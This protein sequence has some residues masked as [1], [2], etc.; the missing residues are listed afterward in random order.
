MG[1]SMD[2]LITGGSGFIGSMLCNYLLEENHNVSVLTRSRGAAH[3][4]IPKEVSLYESME[5]FSDTDFFDVIINLAGESLSH[6]RWTAEKKKEI[7]DSR[8]NTTKAVC[9]YITKVQKKPKLLINGS[10]IG[11]YGSQGDESLD[12]ESEPA[13]GFAHDLCHSW[14]LHAKD[15][16]REGV[17]VCY[18][19]LGVVLHPSGGALKQM[20][21]PF[22]LGL[23]GPIGDGGQYFSWIHMADLIYLIQFII[24]NKSVAGPVNATAP[25]PVPNKEFSK[26]LAAV[27]GRPALLKMPAFPLRLIFGEMADE[28]L[29]N[30]QRVIPKKLLDA[31]FK[32]Q[33][34]DIGSALRDLLTDASSADDAGLSEDEDKDD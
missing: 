7:L 29:L 15:A 20:L 9:E 24:D 6:G 34:A 11:Y 27:L 17:R 2:F 5:S 32:F 10:A 4:K 13:T 8:V 23:G 33:F 18:L 3:L 16:E 22:K 31:G 19:R 1:K 25:E 26:T 28:L 12:E 21:V 14:E 30:G